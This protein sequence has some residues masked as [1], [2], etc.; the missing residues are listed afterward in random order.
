MGA[1]TQRKI[2]EAVHPFS[3]YNSLDKISQHIFDS[4]YP[5]YDLWNQNQMRYFNV[6]NLP[7]AYYTATWNYPLLLT[8]IRVH[9]KENNSFADF[10]LSYQLDMDREMILYEENGNTKVKLY[11]LFML[12]I[13]FNDMIFNYN[14]CESLK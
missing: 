14:V 7:I 13:S 4:S 3:K 10:Y 11:F 5:Y 9:V 6:N 1:F 2:I 12:M 8:G